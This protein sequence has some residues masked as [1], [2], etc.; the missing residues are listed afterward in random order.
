MAA[1]EINTKSSLHTRCNSLPS[2]AHPFV[3][4]LQ[5][6]LQRLKGSETTSS[7]S[8]SSVCHKLND[9]LDLHDCIDKLL[10]LPIEQQILARECN[11]RRVNDLL[12]GSL[13]LLDISSTIKD[14][15]LQSKESMCKLQSVIRR[16]RAD[17][18]G[19][20]TDGEI[21]LASR[22]KMKRTIQKALENL[23]GIKQE[24][25]A[26]FS[27]KNNNLSPMLRFLKDT[28][29][30][31]LSSLEHLF[32]FIYDPKRHSKQSRWLAI[33]KLMQAKRVNC[34]SQDSD[35]NEFE[36]VDATL[37]S[38]ISRKS[39]SIDKFQSHMENL[40]MCIQDLEIEIDQLSRKL[41]RNRVSLLNIF[42]H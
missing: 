40:Q 2:A 3:S 7:L 30:F 23:K 35:I 8:S 24:E 41:I 37:Q 20:T 11:E 27:N 32:Q 18:T 4:Q 36:K 16:R 39:S 12:E 34:H 31:T 19:L 10:Q 13:R 29:A 38:L 28:E 42:N 33:S 6:D 25:V 9:M 1:I 15:L 21:Y 17:E 26:S 22:K 14:C 5:E